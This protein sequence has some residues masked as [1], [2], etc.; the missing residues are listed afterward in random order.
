MSNSQKHG[1]WTLASDGD[2]VVCSVCGTD[3]CTLV[4]HTDDFKFFPHC[5]AVMDEKPGKDEGKMNTIPYEQRKAVYEKAIKAYGAESQT[6]KFL[7]E[8]AELQDAI[9]KRCFLRDSVEHVAEEIADVTIMLE[10]LR[11]IFGVN[12]LVCECMDRKVER[13][14]EKLEEYPDKPFERF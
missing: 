6:W 4:Y 3:F 13:L 12:D 7:E 1:R 5:G 10:Q 2:G 9:C 11:I 14:K 8:V